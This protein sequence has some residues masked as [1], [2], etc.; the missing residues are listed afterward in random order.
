MLDNLTFL[1]NY[2]GLAAALWLGMYIVT[3]SPKRLTS[4]L[5]S[6]TLWTMIGL[7]LNVL[8]TLT[9]PPAPEQ[10]PGWL[11]VF[12]GFFREDP[13]LGSYTWLYKWQATPVIV[14]WYHFTLRMRWNR[15]GRWQWASLIFAYVAGSICLL[16]QAYTHDILVPDP[17]ASP[18]RLGTLRP[19]PLYIPF[20]VLGCI[21]LMMSYFNLIHCARTAP[22]SVIRYKFVAL[23]AATVTGGIALAL[24]VAGSGLDWSVPSAAGS[25]MLDLTIVLIGYS[26]TRYSALAEGR[27]MRRDFYYNAIAACLVVGVYSLVTWVSVQ[28]FGVPEAA[29]IFVI[30]L[31]I[32]TH[33]LIDFARR[34]V[35]RFVFRR[36]ALQ[37]RAGLQELANRAGEQ[38]ELGEKL[39][40]ALESICASARA[41]YGLIL[42]FEDSVVQPIASCRWHLKNPPLSPT[43]LAAD[44]V[45]HLEPGQL[46]PPLDKAALLVPLYSEAEQIGALVLGRPENG[47][48]YSE[49]DV[50]RLLYPTDRLADA[51]RDARR[52]SEFVA[53]VAQVIENDEPET[54]QLSERISVKAV[55]DA[56][57]H[58]FDY[59]YLGDH[60]LAEFY[61]VRS[62]IDDGPVTHLDLGKATYNVLAEAIDKLRPQD[63]I[64]GDP[65]PREWYPYLILH[66]AYVE[67][68]PNRDIMTRLYISEGTFN[69]TRRAALRAVTRALEEMEMAMQ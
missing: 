4:W 9:P 33:S 13:I 21:Y 26:V 22:A 42:L 40:V 2:I 55:E 68:V 51:I 65:P 5:T 67:D 29:F 59:A 15:Y 14:F 32:I 66:N 43:V 7:F 25:L 64:P 34:R 61:L 56:L 60:D 58:L 46:A 47:V 10:G 38:D 17:T 39:S 20:V 36:E 11:R 53:R 50:D 28:A 24:S 18:I 31:V 57:R 44:D 3:R 6:L 8:F 62:R 30:S 19:G 35:D 41:L 1:I 23:A 45:L 37:L 52:R 48:R 27:T 12:Y 63:D 49:E 54:L 16:L 69:R